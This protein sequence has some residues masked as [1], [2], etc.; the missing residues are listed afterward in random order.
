MSHGSSK[1]APIFRTRYRIC[2][3]MPVMPTEVDLLSSLLQALGQRRWED[4]VR[5]GE[6]I[7]DR[8]ARRGHARVARKLR[9]ALA[10]R[11]GAEVAE[12]F[13]PTPVGT[14][15]AGALLPVDPVDGLDDV[16][17]PSPLRAQLAEVLQ[18]WR[19]RGQARP[20]EPPVER[21]PPRPPCP[22]S[23]S[24]CRVARGSG[25][26]ATV[27]STGVFGWSSSLPAS[28]TPPPSGSDPGTAQ[29]TSFSAASHTA[30][31]HSSIHDASLILTRG[32]KD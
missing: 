23:F 4:A 22:A 18:E 7:A 10:S 20:A 19:H 32:P 24:P 12:A 5:L 13:S 8:E 25:F 27:G 15:L 1:P 26:A 9:G 6:E 31:D 17:L 28:A 30:M 29:P 2:T 21:S 3:T 16:V 14:H 11:D